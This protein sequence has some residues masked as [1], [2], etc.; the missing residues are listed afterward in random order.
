MDVVDSEEGFF[1]PGDWVIH[2][3]VYHCDAQLSLIKRYKHSSHFWLPEFISDDEEAPDFICGGWPRKI[4]D[5]EEARS[6]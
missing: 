3:Q 1:P 6:A 4:Q 5:I 2:P